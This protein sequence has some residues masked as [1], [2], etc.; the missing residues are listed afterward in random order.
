MAAAQGS[1]SAMSAE[2]A[3]SAESIVRRMQS[4]QIFETSKVRGRMT[5]ID[6]FGTN[7]TTFLSY[8]RGTS[9]TL[10]EFTSPEEKGQKI[11][12]TRE[13]IY[14]FYPGAEELIRLQGAAFRDAVL[15]SDMSYE[16][17]TGG[18]TIL[19]SYEVSLEGTEAV[20][21]AECYRI[22]MKAKGRNV[23]YPRQTV[24]VDAALWSPRR[25][26]QYSLSNRL[27]KETRLSDFKRIAGR[28]VPMRVELED[29][30]KK[31]SRTEFVVEEIAIGVPLDP[32]LFS[33]EN[34]T[35]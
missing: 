4:N 20:D 9:D 2:S 7:V 14:L 5:V 28:V 11:L 19:E 18:K 22:A 15:G 6:R 8:S 12:R 21:G 26:Q 17:L 24:W 33:L 23:A 34:L 30:L 35:W 1:E 27:L 29:K 3:I 13:E 31:N 25:M 32:S 10:I 16:D